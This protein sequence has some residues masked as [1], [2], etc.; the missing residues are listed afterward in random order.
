MKK[1]IGRSF[2]S[3]FNC[4]KRSPQLDWGSRIINSLLIIVIGVFL[5]PKTAYLSSITP[6]RLIEMTNI[7]R[8]EAGTHGL[9]E[10]VYLKEAAL[11]KAESILAKQIFEH[12]INGRKFSSWVK[13]VGYE[14]SYVGENLAIDFV[15]SEGV[16]K[17]W[18][19]SRGH[20]ENL[21]N[22]EYSEIGI[23]VVEDYFEGAY[24]TIVVQIFGTPA[25][26][27]VPVEVASRNEQF[28]PLEPTVMSASERYRDEAP[29]EKLTMAAKIKYY[30]HSQKATSTASIATIALSVFSALLL[31]YLYI[32]F[33]SYMAENLPHRKQ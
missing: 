22:K 9:E 27:N 5:F 13:E 33:L 29:L 30:L 19:Q 12:N 23:A 1:I 11:R 20:R 32:F 25:K 28:R 2:P 18:L 15:S 26:I 16:I 21:L 6:E 14:Y 17:A 10:N 24:T 3:C 8:R 31:T 7:E 4:L